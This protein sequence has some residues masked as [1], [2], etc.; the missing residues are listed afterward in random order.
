M[1]AG[2]VSTQDR[3]GVIHTNG[4]TP[5]PFMVV[6]SAHECGYGVAIDQFRTQSA[7]RYA[8]K[9]LNR[10]VAHVDRHA[11]VGCKVVAS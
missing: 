8:A 11:V 3:Y 4:A 2:T 10:G 7:A 1:S 5:V 9:L 6:D